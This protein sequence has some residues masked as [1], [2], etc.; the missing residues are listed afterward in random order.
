MRSKTLVVAVICAFTGAML[1]SG[2]ATAEPGKNKPKNEKNCKNKK[3][4]DKKCKKAGQGGDL[5]SD[6]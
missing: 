3:G 5:P 2:V 6:R 4:K 1:L